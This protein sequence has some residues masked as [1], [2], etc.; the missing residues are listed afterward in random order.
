[1]VNTRVLLAIRLH[2]AAFPNAADTVEG[3]HRWWLAE[4]ACPLDDVQLVLDHL[5]GR[6][7][8]EKHTL[9]DGTE[10]YFAVSN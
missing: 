8:L 3:V 4:L 10:V 5:V 7:E 1:M 9:A 2:C 6:G